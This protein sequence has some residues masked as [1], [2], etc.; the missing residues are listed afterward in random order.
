MYTGNLSEEQIP[1]V[2]NALS[3]FIFKYSVLDERNAK[4]LN[5]PSPKSNIYLIGA[6]GKAVENVDGI[7]E[8]GIFTAS[9]SA[10][11]SQGNEHIYTLDFSVDIKDVNNTLVKAPNLDGEEVTYST[12]GHEFDS[13]YVGKYKSDI[14]K[15]EKNSFEKHGER[16]IEIT[17]VEDGNIKGKYYEIYNEGYQA[18]NPASFDFYSKSDESMYDTFIHYTNNQ[19]EKKTGAIHTSGLDAQNINA[20]FNITIDKENGGYSY[21]NDD[22][23]DNRFIRVFKRRYRVIKNIKIRIY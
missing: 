2:A 9:I 10:Q 4:R 3:S 12:E 1:S 17:S 22:G 18:Q 15:V 20:S 5:V 8:S 23:F 7:L 19:G 14:V 21:D 6:S 16:F 13:K 11:D